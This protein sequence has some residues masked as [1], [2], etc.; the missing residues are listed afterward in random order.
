MSYFQSLITGSAFGLTL[1]V[2]VACVRRRK[3]GDLL[4]EPLLFGATVALGLAGSLCVT[5]SVAAQT[6]QA[7][8]WWGAES[9][10]S[11][12]G[13]PLVAG[14]AAGIVAGFARTWRTR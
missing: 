4:R 13:L 9:V 1:T 11:L 2:A 8:P 7:H 5:M 12:V 14:I 6:S 10:W 3:G